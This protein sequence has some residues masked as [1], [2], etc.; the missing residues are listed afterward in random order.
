MNEGGV[1]FILITCLFKRG[2]KK[3]GRLH[4]FI[5]KRIFIKLT[6]QNYMLIHTNYIDEL[7]LYLLFFYYFINFSSS[8]FLS[9]LEAFN[10]FIALKVFDVES[11][12]KSFFILTGYKPLGTVEVI[13]KS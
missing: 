13:G 5:L 12:R 6:H 3:D 10:L 1:W 2:G 9:R 7:L 8:F 4:P 11:I